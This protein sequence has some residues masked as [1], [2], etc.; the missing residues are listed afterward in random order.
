MYEEVNFNPNSISLQNR[1]KVRFVLVYKLLKS[2]ISSLC[3]ISN[4]HLS[5]RD[6]STRARE[7]YM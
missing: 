2:L 1:C 6:S 7:T 3:G 4:T 5:R